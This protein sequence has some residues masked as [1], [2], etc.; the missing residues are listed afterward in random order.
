MPLDLKEKSPHR[1]S[2]TVRISSF[3]DAQ[4][5]SW[6]ILR[7]FVI[8]F[9]VFPF[10]LNLRYQRLPC[11]LI[12]YIF[13]SNLALRGSEETNNNSYRDSTASVF[14]VNKI[15]HY[16]RSNKKKPNNWCLYIFYNIF[17]LAWLLNTGAKWRLYQRPLLVDKP[18]VYVVILTFC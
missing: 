5:I 7:L 4:R 14:P 13:F 16:T 3:C 12:S 9:S 1:F 11:F 8:Y 10:L 2:Y 17:H 15:M 18:D 6:V